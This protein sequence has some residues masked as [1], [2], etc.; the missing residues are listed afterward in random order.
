[1]SPAGSSGRAST[2][3]DGPARVDQ[4]QRRQDIR[5]D[6]SPRPKLSWLDPMPVQLGLEDPR[7]PGRGRT[8]RPASPAGGGSCPAVL[9]GVGPDRPGRTQC[10]TRGRGTRPAG[11]ARPARRPARGSPPRPRRP[12][13]DTPTPARPA[14][15]ARRMRRRAAGPPRRGPSRRSPGPSGRA[16]TDGGP[17]H[18]ARSGVVGDPPGAGEVLRRPSGSRRDDLAIDGWSRSACGRTIRSASA[19]DRSASLWAIRP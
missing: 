4:R 3:R 6:D 17:G 13:P 16:H 8:G 9:A 19:G 18:P 5:R 11:P 12:A 7:R 2:H 1:M 14:A 15:P 10:R